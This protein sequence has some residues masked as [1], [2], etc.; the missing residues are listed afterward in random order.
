MALGLGRTVPY[1]QVEARPVHPIAHLEE[2]YIHKGSLGKNT[3]LYRERLI[4]IAVLRRSSLVNT[5]RVTSLDCFCNA[6]YV[7]P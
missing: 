4:Y 1:Q 3:C 7:M 2:R 5:L 6:P